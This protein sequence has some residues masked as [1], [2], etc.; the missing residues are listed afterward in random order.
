MDVGLENGLIRSINRRLKPLHRRVGRARG[1]RGGRN[2][3]YYLIDTAS[4]TILESHLDLSAFARELGEVAAGRAEGRMPI[5]D[6]VKR[7]G[8]SQRT[9][10]DWNRGGRLPRYRVPGMK[11]TLVRVDEVKAALI[12][13]TRRSARRTD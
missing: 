12:S 8:I 13:R 5:S 9:L 7:Y 10:H 1:E 4:G 11:A 2:A 6:V 3:P